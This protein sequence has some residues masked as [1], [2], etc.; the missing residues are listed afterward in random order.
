MFS[1]CPPSGL[2]VC[3]WLY[4]RSICTSSPRQHTNTHTSHKT[5]SDWIC[6]DTHEHEMRFTSALYGL[7]LKV[8]TLVT[9]VLWAQIKISPNCTVQPIKTELPTPASTYCINAHSAIIQLP[10]CQ[11]HKWW[12]NDKVRGLYLESQ[13]MVSGIKCPTQRKRFS[14]SL[15]FW[16]SPAGW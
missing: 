4:S 3:R 16:V 6:I 5:N 11:Q 12:Q 1:A 10:W 13:H 7:T 8:V 14:E 2:C 9:L 15:T